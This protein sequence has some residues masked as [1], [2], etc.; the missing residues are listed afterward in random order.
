[1]KPCSLPVLLILLLIYQTGTAQVL[2]LQQDSSWLNIGD[3]DIAGNQ[4]TVE[5]LIYRDGT[6]TS[7]IVSKHS[8]PDDVN[9]LLRPQTFELTTYISGTAG[10]TQFLQMFNP[11]TLDL[12]KWYHIAGTYDGSVV[13]YYV[14]GCVVIE[15]PF[16]GN[17]LQNDFVAAIGN[18]SENQSEQ[19]FGKMDE[20]RIWNVCRTQEQ[21][22]SNMLNLPNPTT[23]TGLV[24]Y[25]QFGNDFTNTQGNAT[26]NGTAMGTPQFTTSVINIPSFEITSIETTS[27]DCS[28]LH[29]GTITIT[30]NR[31]NSLYSIDGVNYQANNF[32]SDVNGGTYTI[33]V[34]SPE[35]CII[36]SIATVID[37]G[38]SFPVTMTRII[39][40]GENYAGYTTT[41]TYLDTLLNPGSCDSIRTLNL[42]VHDTFQFTE[43]VTICPG[44]TYDFHGT[45][46]SQ[47]GS[48]SA[49][50]L[51]SYGC[52][53]S[54]QL[55]LTVLPGKFLG[56]DTVICIANSFDIVSDVPYTKWF[57][58]TISPAKTVTSSGWYWAVVE[59]ASGCDVVD[60]IY[61]QFNL[62]FYVP[63]AFTPNQNGLND[64]F[65]PI[66]S[67]ND[68]STYHLGIFDRW[69]K[70]LFVSDDPADSWDGTSGGKVCDIGTYIYLLTVETIFCGSSSVHGNITIVK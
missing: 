8:F 53:S 52:D 42:T 46:L 66:F 40:E 37:N 56:N 38:I 67:D 26:W 23:Q 64:V 21:I 15:Q 57:D 7:N 1:M 60:S 62:K 65:L 68:F 63:T 14:N 70:Q 18:Q 10:P 39:C 16:S 20:V 55:E 24:A 19:F 50:F 25:Y 28:S 31:P 34:K 2:N 44:E 47:S 6:N 41:G 35:G 12:Q 9:Y 11:F 29:N 30:S 33:Y 5:A 43:D 32:F 48:Y 27:S 4:I 36:D 49:S 54:F 13:K 58:N 69:G 17:L 45:L 61:V 51:T 59:D 22:T 3:L